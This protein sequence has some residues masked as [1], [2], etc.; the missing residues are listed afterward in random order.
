M[1]QV[2]KATGLNGHRLLLM[3]T[4][5]AKTQRRKRLQTKR[6]IL[7]GKMDIFLQRDD[8]SRVVPD[9]LSV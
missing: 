3:K 7:R 5:L 6:N 1:K 2:S 4:K 9:K 8:N